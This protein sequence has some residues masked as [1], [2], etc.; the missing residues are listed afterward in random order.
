M[1]NISYSN[2]NGEG[3]VNNISYYSHSEENNL[4]LSSYFPYLSKSL[5]NTTFKRIFSNVSGNL[6]G[7]F[8][9]NVTS[10]EF[11]P[12]NA[13]YISSS[14]AYTKNYNTG[15]LIYNITTSKLIV[16]LFEIESNP[17]SNNLSIVLK[18][19]YPPILELE[20]SSFLDNEYV[21]STQLVRCPRDTNTG[22]DDID[23]VWL[24]DTSFSLNN[25]M[26]TGCGGSVGGEYPKGLCYVA[27]V[28]TL[29]NAT[30]LSAG[31]Y[32]INISANDTSGNVASGIIEV[33]INRSK[34]EYNVSILDNINTLSS[35]QRNYDSTK[36]F[37]D[38]FSI[39]SI[40]QKI[41]SIISTILEFFKLDIF[42]DR[43]MNLFRISNQDI[44]INESLE[45][46]RGMYK[47]F[48]EPLTIS[49][50]TSR[51]SSIKKLF[52]DFFSLD[53][54][55]QRIANL[56]RISN[57]DLSLNESLET[58]KGIDK[59]LNQSF[60]LED[61]STRLS[62]LNRNVSSFIS[63]ESI[64]TRIVNLYRTITSFFSINDYLTSIKS[65]VYLISEYFTMGDSLN[66][67]ASLI[68]NTNDT[69][70]VKENVNRLSSY[71]RNLNNQI[72]ID[73]DIGYLRT[74]IIR[75]NQNVKIN[76]L[77]ERVS[78][79]TI[80]TLQFLSIYD[81]VNK[82][83]SIFKT[84]LDY[85]SIYSNGYTWNVSHLRN[86][87]QVI[88]TSINLQYSQFINRDLIQFFNINE[89]SKRVTD[90]DRNI[91]N[92]FKIES[93]N[94]KSR[95]LFRN[96]FQQISIKSSIGKLQD[97]YKNIQLYINYNDLQNRELQNFKNV[98]QAISI[99]TLSSRALSITRS[100]N[101]FFSMFFNIFKTLT[102]SD[103]WLYLT[104]SSQKIQSPAY[105]NELVSWNYVDTWYLSEP[106]TLTNATKSY[107]LPLDASNVK[108]IIDGYD[109]TSS[110]Y[111]SHNLNNY[112]IINNKTFTMGSSSIINISY[113]TGKIYSEESSWLAYNKRIYQNTTWRATLSTIN[114]SSDNY[115]NVNLNITTDIEAIPSSITV[116]YSNGTLIPH[117]FTSSNGNVNWTSNIPSSDTY[118]TI[119]YKTPEVELN[120]E[121]YEVTDGRTKYYYNLTISTES[122]R[123][124]KN[125]FSYLDF[126]DT[127]IV[128]TKF[129]QCDSN[130]EDCTEISNSSSVNFIDKDS[131]DIPDRVEWFGSVL[132]KSNSEYFQLMLDSGLPVN[133]TISEEI[134]NSPIQPFD[135]IKWQT[136]I[137]MYNPNQFGVEKI[138]KFELPSGASSINLDGIN[139]NLQYDLYGLYSPYV[140]IVDVNDTDYSSSVYLEP[141][142]TKS[143]LLLYDTD[144]VTV[145]TSTY[146]P[147][148][149]EVGKMAEINKV[150]R[151]KNQADKNVTG[152]EYAVPIDYAEDLRVCFGDFR[153][154][155]P[156][157]EDSNY[158][159]L[160]LDTQNTVRGEYNLEI[161]EIPS[162]ETKIVTLTYYVPTVILDNEASGRRSINGV[163]T[164]YK[165][166]D[167]TSQA[168]FTLDSV[169][170]RETSVDC[171][172]IVDVLACDYN[173]ICDIPL[174]YTCDTKLGLGS[175]GVGETK[176]VYLWYLE[177]EYLETK[178]AQSTIDSIL[179]FGSKYY[180][181]KGG[182]WYYILGL[183]SVDEDGI[184]YI[185]TGRLILILFSFLLIFLFF[186]FLIWLF[187]DK[188]DEEEKKEKSEYLNSILVK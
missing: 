159:N 52:Q 23:S 119:E 81:E 120:S 56:F 146:F 178:T 179:N 43:L 137:T 98:N 138:L 165:K 48:D 76:Y 17:L 124:I 175:F 32:L 57:Q 61:N 147:S 121:E 60:N 24:N 74:L 169:K 151:I 148:Y 117:T 141:Q 131:D 3:L 19:I 13:S 37:L 6:N 108:V 54:L 181:E 80:N 122:T 15:D 85:F 163:L 67:N 101:S 168:Y 44:S 65:K 69:M 58:Q 7:T 88:S 73:S 70:V 94:L 135:T 38:S 142:Q 107:V 184:T 143:F 183:F 36:T 126:S 144:S 182:F 99:E 22:I 11:V 129:Y 64:S 63:I 29:S 160:T 111:V 91:F 34:L 53:L 166:Y 8:T 93:L 46:Q 173:N 21:Y 95:E 31:K 140:T 75:L 172:K 4:L 47:L 154:G 90:L 51:I 100:I 50:S 79:N 177:E 116:K 97:L 125:I 1:W 109:F 112:V 25:W 49:D 20:N 92:S 66:K 9:I 84:F 186:I 106:R 155:C 174:S 59:S 145:F 45:T 180:I 16:N 158:K 113:T 167:F 35:N 132:S 105:E 102:L 134:L 71:F 12:F 171:S 28:Y 33:E 161:G 150:L 40:S 114:P 139:K 68:R 96:I 110:P 55:T 83:S 127:G 185:T 77:Q 152:L 128:S 42:S 78:N 27:Y 164:T 115:S 188:D 149:Y 82:V 89:F 187:S 41:K 62:S 10:G 118:F 130:F 39:K 136:I 87:Q 30:N 176:L 14:G 2:P 104:S 26:T 86:T 123:D 103:P 162:E 18:D 72:T 157:E 133:I 153:D 170:Y 5:S 156:D